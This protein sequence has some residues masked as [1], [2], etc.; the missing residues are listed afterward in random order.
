MVCTAEDVTAGVLAQGV[1]GLSPT[2]VTKGIFK[3][4]QNP[5]QMP[6]KPGLAH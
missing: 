3:L 2:G 5:S 6:R 1:Q 4:L